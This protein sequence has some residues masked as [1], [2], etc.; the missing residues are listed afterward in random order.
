VYLQQDAFSEIDAASPVERQR[1]MFEMM[2]KA[3]L[4]TYSFKQKDEARR[5]FQRLTQACIDW[6]MTTYESPEY[7]AR[8]EALAKTLKEVTH[9]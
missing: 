9:V 6:N 2:E 1:E 5:F 7:T 3:L 4:I 8:K